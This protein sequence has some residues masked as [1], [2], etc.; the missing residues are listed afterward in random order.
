LPHALWITQVSPCITFE[1]CYV[2]LAICY[3]L[4]V[5]CLYSVT[6]ELLVYVVTFVVCNVPSS[7][8]G[9]DTSYPDRG[10]SLFSFVHPGECQDGI[11]K[12]TI[13]A[14]SQFLSNSL[15][16][17][18]LSYHLILNNCFSWYSVIQ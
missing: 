17:D 3:F 16:A 7:N 10:F 8:P 15:N 12:L 2:R 13:T 9:Q 6:C 1:D 4:M 18:I 14:S 11:L 5:F